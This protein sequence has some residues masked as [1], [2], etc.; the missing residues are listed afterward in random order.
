MRAFWTYVFKGGTEEA[1]SPFTLALVFCG[2][3]S[4][5]VQ[6]LQNGSASTGHYYGAVAKGRLKNK[7][8]FVYW[9]DQLHVF[10]KLKPN[11]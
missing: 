7:N 6:T 1:R 4:C 2:S 11:K 9:A 8:K 3:V 5:G 10:S